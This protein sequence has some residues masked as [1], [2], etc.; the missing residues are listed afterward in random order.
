MLLAAASTAWAANPVLLIQGTGNGGGDVTA[1]VDQVEIVR[2]SNSTVIGGAVANASFETPNV[3]ANS[4]QYNPVGA[5]WTFTGNSGISQAGGGFGP[6]TPP[7]G[8]Q[9]ALVQTT[10][11]IQQT[12]TL[13]SGTYVVRFLT[14]QR[15][16]CCGA[17]YNQQL[18]VYIGG[19][20]VGS[21]QPP[22]NNV[23]TQ[24]T[25]SAF[26]V[27]APTLTAVSPNPG[28][29]GQAITLTGTDLSNPTA[30][31]INGVNALTN[32]ISNTGTSVVVRVPATAAASGNVSIT[33]DA[34]TATRTFT[35]MA[36]PGNALAFDG[37]D[38]VALPRS[39]QNDFTLEY[40]VNTTQ[41]GSGAGGTQWWQGT[42]LV[43]AEVGSITT[44]FGTSLLGN[45]VAFGIG[46]DVTIQST[47]SINDGRWHHVAAVRRASTGQL[48]LYIDGRLEN[49]IAGTIT[50]ALTAPSRITL[51]MTQTGANALFVGRLD[52]L[53]IWNTARTASEIASNFRTDLS[54]PQT[55]LVA[56]YNF[57]AGTPGGNNA[58][59]TTLYDL[60][61]NANHGTL[62]AFTLT[63]TTSNWV[64]S[65]A[66]VVPI[67]T[68]ATTVLGNSFTANWTAPTEG[69]VTTYYVEVA[70]D[71][72]F[73]T[74]LG[75]FSVAA[76][77]T[78]LNITG[79]ANATT[80]YYRVRADK[81]SVT[82]Q[83]GT[84]FYTSVT[85]LPAPTITG[86]SPNPGVRGEAVTITGTNLGG[87][88]S[89]TINGVAVTA[90][91]FLNNTTTSITV[92][93][94]ATA[95][96][97]GTT[98]VT[99][100]TNGTGSTTGFTTVAATPPG[101]ALALDGAND[102]VQLPTGFNTGSF[103]FEAWVNYQDN[104][105]WTRIF[106]FGSGTN[107]WMMLTPKSGYAGAVN[108]IAFGITNSGGGGG[109][110][111]IT[112]STP[113]PVGRW[114]HIAVTLATTGSV[115]SGTLYLNGNVIGTNP[116]L[117]ISPA[118]LGTLTNSWLGRSQYGQ[119]AFLK[120]SLDEVRIYN[121][122]LN[123]AQVQADM[124]SVS[125]TL[126][127]NLVA[128]FNFDQ[129]A[130]T[131]GG[132]NT[133]QTTLYDQT[134][135]AY[136][137]TL[138]NFALTGATSNWIE[139]Y[140]MVVPTATAATAVT[141]NGFTANWTA[142]AIGTVNNYLV[143]VATNTAFTTGL[144]TT[145]VAAPALSRAITGLTPSTTYYYRVRAD[146]TSVTGQGAP[147]N[148][149]TVA[150]CALPT[151]VAQ[152]VTLNLDASGNA[153]LNATQVNN[154]STAN[155]GPALASNLSL[156]GYVTGTIS[157]EVPEGGTLTLTAPNGGIF[158]AVTFASYGTPTGTPGNYATSGCDAASSLAVVRAALIGNNSGS[159]GANNTVFGDPCYG[160]VKKL[161]VTATYEYYSASAP[162]ATSIAYSCA[163]I[164]THYVRLVVTDAGGNTASTQ[165]RVTVQDNLAPTVVTRNV[166][167]T[168]DAN[169]TASV[170]AAQVNNGS[171]DN[172]GIASL[173]VS[174]NTFT[175]ANTSPSAGPANRYALDF[176][177]TNDRVDLGSSVMTGGSYTKEAWVFAR[178]NN[179]RNIL[180][181]NNQQQLWVPSALNAGHQTSYSVV[182]DPNGAFP[183]N[184]WVHVAVSYNAAT[185]TMRLYR[186]GA[187]VATSTTAPTYSAGILSIGS[188]GT[189]GGC[190]WD[191]LIDEVRIWNTV[192]TASEIQASKDVTLAGTETG[193]QAYYTFENGPNSGTLT[194]VT[195][196]G[197]DGV[198]TNMATSTA[199]VNST[200]PITGGT[201]VTLTAT[202]A[203]GNTSQATATV[204]V[205][206]PPTPTTTWNGNTSTNWTDCSNWSFGK[207]PDA[208]TNVVIPTGMPRYPSITTGVNPVN[209]L[210]VNTGGTLT[211]AA[212]AT[213]QV[214]GNLT[215]S[216][217]ATLSGTVEFVGSTATQT[218][219]NSGGFGTVVVNKTS[220]TVQLG[221]N[222]TI[223][224]ALTLTSGTLTTTG[225]YQVN[226]GGSAS[227]SE[228]ETSY[229][230]GKVVVSRTLT[231]GT[232]QSFSGLGLTLTPAAGS[233]SPGATQVSR[234]TG[235]ALT[236]VN[237]HQSVQR[238][239]DIQPAV[240]TGLNITMVFNYFNHELNGIP[241]ANLAL[242]KST[243]GTSGPWQWQRPVTLSAN[244]VTKTGIT[245]FS[246]WTL[247][248]SLSPLPVELTVFTATA[249]DN[250]AA[251][252]LAWTT[253]S[254]KNSD[255]FE[256]ERS[257]DG[258][259]FGVI[260]RVAA[261]G[262]ASSAST[263]ALL[264]SRLPAQANVLY[265][266]LRQVDADGTVAYSPVRTVQLSSKIAGE[267][268]LMPNP[269]R[270]TTLTG[271][272]AGAAVE[273]Y[274]AVGRLVLTA[275]ADADGAAALVL[276]AELA[277]G[278]YIVRSGSK[279]VRL[280][281]E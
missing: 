103:T 58:G 144:T 199:W 209:S 153:T 225:T 215:N 78:S 128:Y 183:L 221:Q 197:Y 134:N 256:V 59:L 23:Y 250:A 222:L 9:V 6:P 185:S 85:T 156:Q 233:V 278:V 141:S 268:S 36:A 227:I 264:D 114:S 163:S 72:G 115:T 266:R 56:Y 241:T 33:T 193:L 265:Y 234:T 223:N 35:V 254:E 55:G 235:T 120:S 127:A 4:F 212:G 51:G 129:A 91:S 105:A 238:Y 246:I 157:N 116:N 138:N 108:N 173:T 47:T 202:D 96:A 184:T 122:A 101:N 20:F 38:Y 169:G 224:T 198:L 162:A 53:R 49:N 86:I 208:A 263:Y 119:D 121:A 189:N 87:A 260:G 213:V 280:A 270:A 275:K 64:E 95:G 82:G 194:D 3:G 168:L 80:Y 231:A 12:L 192:R 111:A 148:T 62:N 154:G 31:T 81:T 67:P 253:A 205:S 22:A 147:S 201:L 88:T 133:G 10:G 106:D 195:G 117:G 245:D 190:N 175:C 187:L 279:A 118:S 200:A 18:N 90:A 43:D 73:T 7:N 25:S 226:L 16:N 174:P 247:G 257:L 32:I 61:S 14:T 84:Y 131:P 1:F 15:T 160:T 104:G 70:T 93:V 2:V 13:G 150:S 71:A 249:V 230:V 177:G 151:A 63:G 252:R 50:G 237:S 27:D 126:P 30:L 102:Y 39:V 24:F 57:D 251:V 269:A 158:T 40:W 142:P 76:P 228:S 206:V 83:G 204:T 267:L 203:S 130:N 165:A 74:G 140:A 48:E 109:E 272:Q 46:G 248:N 52:E 100:P 274:D 66:L 29:L 68:A 216:G 166:T 277:T 170:T 164:G 243:T 11:S 259:S 37:S 149:I 28:G 171:S 132:T 5:S 220:G 271:A 276:P 255:Y 79:R 89:V 65:Y 146:K 211:L 229:V 176:D 21:I 214:N 161:A 69:T 172:C 54:V 44:D 152:N 41:T 19:A 217:T 179:C 186:N 155:C 136:A 75:T 45:K 97:S 244:A 139:S 99:T 77:A 281:V 178:N 60:T 207:V 261:A 159:I 258:T 143:D 98:S 8:A 196:H 262:T 219:T 110:P 181:A 92:R 182:S 94:P 145:T 218:L 113:M 42:G 123:Q 242:F 137:G 239:F 210:T 26:V 236:G 180:S 240:N 273:V 191:G 232:A 17:P 125:S 34:G 112:S 188:H 124:T 107:S 135:N 167:V